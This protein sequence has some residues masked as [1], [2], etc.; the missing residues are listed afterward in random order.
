MTDLIRGAECAELT[1]L[2]EKTLANMRSRKEGPPYVR[3]S[4]G[5]IRYS[6]KAVAAWLDER[7]VMPQRAAR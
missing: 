3:V 4:R 6:R 2:T 5:A 7:T 1:G